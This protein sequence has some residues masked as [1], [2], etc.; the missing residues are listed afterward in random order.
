METIEVRM[1][2]TKKGSVDGIRVEEHLAGSTYVLPHS[3][4]STYINEGWAEEVKKEQKKQAK[5]NEEPKKSSKQKKEKG[6]IE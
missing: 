5:N 4:A 3:L 6:D 1:K 2:S